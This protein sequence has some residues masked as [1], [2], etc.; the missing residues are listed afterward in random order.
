[1]RIEASDHC[2]RRY[3][4]RVRPG[5]D[6]DQADRELDELLKVLLVVDVRPE[7]MTVRDPDAEGPVA[8]LGDTGIAFPLFRERRRWLAVTCVTRGGQSP[9]RRARRN[10][11][12]AARRAARRSRRDALRRGHNGRPDDG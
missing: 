12:R 3:H 10:A 9:E 8:V 2:R 5:L 7:W 1:M 4:E 11:W 6:R